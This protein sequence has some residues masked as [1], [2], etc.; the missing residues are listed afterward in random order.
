M[1][2]AED[3]PGSGGLRWTDERKLTWGD[4]GVWSRIWCMFESAEPWIVYADCS[5]RWQKQW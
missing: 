2:S 1:T 4:E 5:K 3:K